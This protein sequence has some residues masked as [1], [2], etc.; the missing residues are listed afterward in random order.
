MPWTYTQILTV[1][2]NKEGGFGCFDSACGKGFRAGTPKCTPNQQCMVYMGINRGCGALWSGW[3]YI[4]Q[5]LEDRGCDCLQN[6]TK[7]CSG[8][9]VYNQ[10]VPDSYGPP[11]KTFT[12][13]VFEYYRDNYI[14]PEW[15]NL[16]SLADAVLLCHLNMWETAMYGKFKK[17]VLQASSDADVVNIINGWG[18]K[19]TQELY[20]KLAT[21]KICCGAWPKGRKD[22]DPAKRAQAEKLLANN[23]NVM[24]EDIKN[25]NSFPSNNGPKLLSLDTSCASGYSS[26]YTNQML[27]L[28]ENTMQ[29][30]AIGTNWFLS[31]LGMEG[32]KKDITQ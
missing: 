22:P 11:G 3:Q 27:Q 17:N 23:L 24:G 2:T 8:K 7:T 18:E 21:W 12:E 6:P 20:C 26:T 32:N 9:N 25:A 1:A 31:H 15:Y 10:R 4:D 19:S 16:N 29:F 30:V 5:W 13:L 14:K 28:A